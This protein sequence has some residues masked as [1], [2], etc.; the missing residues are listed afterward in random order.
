MPVVIKPCLHTFCHFSFDIA[1][2][3]TRL[4]PFIRQLVKERF[5]LFQ[6]V[7]DVTSKCHVRLRQ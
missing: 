1:H 4:I 2:G 6:N 3:W 5:R 7:L